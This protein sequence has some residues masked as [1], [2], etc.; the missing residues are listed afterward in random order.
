MLQL[1]QPKVL[2]ARVQ[3]AE[4]ASSRF[5]ISARSQ[6]MRPR[7][8]KAVGCPEK[9]AHA[10][11]LL[12]G[13]STQGAVKAALQYLCLMLHASLLEQLSEVGRYD[14]YRF[15]ASASRVRVH[16]VVQIH[17]HVRTTRFLRAR[18][19]LTC[20]PSSRFLAWST[21][22]LPNAQQ[23]G[24]RFEVGGLGVGS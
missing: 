18:P 8:L 23:R 11:W 19:H 20:K 4:T 15:Y 10:K 1:R 21:E 9:Q 16:M 6:A 24:S 17:L 7:S 22:I 2:Y 12:N 14:R 3:N 5:S 13:A